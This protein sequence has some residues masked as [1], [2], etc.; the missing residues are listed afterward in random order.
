L[1]HI[2]ALAFGDAKLADSL[3]DEPVIKTWDAAF[4]PVQQ[5]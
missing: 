3:P 2:K 4:L 1:R 5:D